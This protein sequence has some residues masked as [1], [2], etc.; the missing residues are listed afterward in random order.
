MG[1][2]SAYIEKLISI[3]PILGQGKTIAELGLQTD[4]QTDKQC[5]YSHE[6]LNFTFSG[7]GWVWLPTLCFLLGIFAVM[8]EEEEEE[9]CLPCEHSASPVRRASTTW[10]GYCSK[11]IN[12]PGVLLFF[13]LLSL[14]FLFLSHL[15]TA[16]V[17]SAEMSQV[18]LLRMMNRQRMLIET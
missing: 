5:F 12:I 18:G 11:A 6:N 7:R 16:T 1:S 8:E 4:R 15:A 14:L 17:G 9:V 3:I 10:L 13:F 2:E